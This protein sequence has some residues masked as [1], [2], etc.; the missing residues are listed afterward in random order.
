MQLNGIGRKLGLRVR[1]ALR[2]RPEEGLPHPYSMRSF[3]K[4][5]QTL[6]LVSGDEGSCVSCSLSPLQETPEIIR[7][8][9]QKA[10]DIPENLVSLTT[11]ASHRTRGDDQLLRLQP[12]LAISSTR[13]PIVE[14]RPPAG[15]IVEWPCD[16]VAVRRRLISGQNDREFLPGHRE[17]I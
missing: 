1:I 11:P 5:A 8:P 3:E 12:T 15:K 9:P 14:I 6:G 7:M 10:L 16:A 4:A 13:S 2:M 17:I